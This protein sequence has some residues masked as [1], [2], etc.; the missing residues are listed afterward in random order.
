VRSPSRPLRFSD[1]IAWKPLGVGLTMGAAALTAAWEL[2]RPLRVRQ[3][4]PD[5]VAHRL[6]RAHGGD[7]LSAFQLCPDLSTLVSQDGRAFLAY[8]AQSGVL[9]ISGD[10]VGPEDALP[11]L[12]RELCAFAA[13]RGLRIGA[14]GASGR[15][16]RPNPA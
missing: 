1:A 5:D 8:R 7:T 2:F 11:A 3:E 15:R 6:L 13:E 16:L 12:L 10:P 14:V 4:P 9:L